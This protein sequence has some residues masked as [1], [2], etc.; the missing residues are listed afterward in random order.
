MTQ[1]NYQNILILFFCALT[2]TS[3]GSTIIVTS[4]GLTFSPDLV[5]IQVGDTVSWQIA[6]VHNV[7][8][9]DESTWNSNGTAPNG[10]FNLPFGGGEVVFDTPGEYYYVC[11]P[12]AGQ[13]MKGRVVVA[14]PEE[15]K[16]YMAYLGGANEVPQRFSPG[17]GLVNAVLNG[18]TLTIDGY[19]LN[20]LSP[21]D[22]SIAGG[23]HLHMGLAGSNGGILFELMLDLDAD[24]R[25]GRFLAADNTFILDEDQKSVL[26]RQ[27]IYINI[28]SSLYQAGELRGQLAPASDAYFGANLMGVYQSP[29]VTTSAYGSV[30]AQLNG[31][32]LT[33]SGSFSGLESDLDTSIIGGVHLHVALAGSNGQVVFPLRTTLASDL[34]SG[35]FN[36]AQNIYSLTPEQI[37]ILG[38]RGFYVNLHT[39]DH[40]GGALRG[41]L[42]GPAHTIYRVHLSGM[43]Q[44]PPLVTSA[45]G[46]LIAEHADTSLIISG[47]FTGLESPLD[48]NI[49]G[50]VHLHVGLAG[51]NGSV[52][53]P[54]NV[55]ASDDL[56]SGS[57]IA[58][59]NTFIINGQ[60]S[61]LLFFRSIYANVHSALAGAG[62]LR[63]Q[64]LPESNR[65][66]YA[67]LTSAQ[68]PNQ[69]VSTGNGQ[70]IGEYNDGLIT[71]S[72]SVDLTSE[73][74][75][76]IAGGIHVHHALAGDNGSVVIPLNLTAMEDDSTVGS[77]LSLNNIFEVPTAFVDTMNMRGQYINVHSVDYPSGEIRGQILG[78]AQNYFFAPLSG[79]SEAPARDHGGQGAMAFEQSGSSLVVS[80]SFNS[81]ESNF[82]P[83]I[84]GGAHLHLGA[85]GQNGG[86]LYPLNVEQDSDGNAGKVIAHHIETSSSFLDTL[87]R[88]A[89]Y[90][91]IHSEDTPGGSV[92]GNALGQSQIYLTTTFSG[93][94]KIQPA[95]TSARGSAKIEL[96]ENR[97]IVSGSFAGLG[98]AFRAAHIHSS[99]PE[100]N[101]PVLQG[102]NIGLSSDS[103]SGRINPGPNY[104]NNITNE[105][106]DALVSENTYINIHSADVPSGEIRGQMLVE[107]N[108]FPDRSA[109]SAPGSG[110][111]IVI[112]GDGTTPFKA[113]WEE[114]TDVDGNVVVYIWQLSPTSDFSSVALS[115]NTGNSTSFETTY[116]ALDDL[117]ETAGIPVGG[118]VTFYHRVL[119]SDGAIQSASAADSVVLTRG[120]ISSTTELPQGVFTIDVMPNPIFDRA[121]IQVESPINGKLSIQIIDMHGHQVKLIKESVFEGRLGHYDL[122]M[123]D[124]PAGIYIV[125]PMIDNKL[126]GVVRIVKQ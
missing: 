119:A 10:G 68:Q 9:V 20:M 111:A 44:N 100:A 85:A 22:V 106:F 54:L 51:S 121:T 71:Y 7:V 101:G 41:Q 60:V 97:A 15:A 69:V 98:S 72:G 86:I 24:M 96:D 103:L 76:N 81:L 17:H 30:V 79:A 91:N 63:G 40:S 102:L 32:L 25:S 33:I 105:L 65:Y 34:R 46:M 84:A 11:Q 122:N 26:D 16:T 21:V 112:E 113:I 27:G 37:L 74:A 88:R 110:A 2:Y 43:N 1:F 124:M 80:G 109:L 52:L 62:E 36:A 56:M 4:A 83:N 31:D 70:I 35:T 5:T 3:V 117:L 48:T 93:M 29:A 118:T 126:L 57:F 95:V 58:N 38:A 28:H 8:Q 14:T 94:N 116:G 53:T 120:I 59:N 75:Y 61:T 87:R 23:A 66:V 90:V 45:S 67:R 73:V 78:E 13:S 55:T 82:N 49:L 107:T 47:S 12:H 77:L 108:H 64:L 18:D 42:R 19:F 39:K 6:D 125:Q 92:R 50:G 123:N 115:V 104:F 99:G 114:A 89:V